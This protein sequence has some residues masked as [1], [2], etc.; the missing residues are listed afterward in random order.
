MPPS[1]PPPDPCAEPLPARALEAIR[2]FNAGEYYRQ[3]DLLEAL[4]RE[5]PRPI[6]NLYQGILQ[7]GVA[8]YQALQG[9]RRGALKMLRR[10]ARWLDGLPAVCQGVDV[11]A[12]RADVAR[13][14]AALLALRDDEMAAF[15]RALLGGVRLTIP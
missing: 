3:H 12:L 10:S 4:W 6:R 9:N 14:Q 15:D 1:A 7:V 13:V 11:A 8:Y 5:E 2:L